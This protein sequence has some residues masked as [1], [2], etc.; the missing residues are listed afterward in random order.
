[1]G[2]GVDQTGQQELTLPIQPFGGRISGIGR[3]DLSDPAIS[4][5]QIDRRAAQWTHIV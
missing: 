3:C 2:M 5:Q 4:N 1:M